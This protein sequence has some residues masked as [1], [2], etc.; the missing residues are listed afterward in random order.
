MNLVIADL[1]PSI[2]GR[3]PGQVFEELTHVFDA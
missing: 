3:V 1:S 2:K